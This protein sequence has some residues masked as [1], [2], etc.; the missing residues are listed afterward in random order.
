MQV[1]TYC[2]CTFSQLYFYLFPLSI[3]LFCFPLKLIFLECIVFPS[4]SLPPS[5]SFLVLLYSFSLFPISLSHIFLITQNSPPTTYLLPFILRLLKFFFFLLPTL[6]K[7]CSLA[8]SLSLSYTHILLLPFP[9]P[10]MALTD[11]YFWKG[12]GFVK[13]PSAL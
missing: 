4:F 1:N 2:H 9:Y 12:W 10:S 7:G 8:R 11:T 5:H 6:S 3:S 13:V